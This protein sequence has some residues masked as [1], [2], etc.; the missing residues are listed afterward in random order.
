MSNGRGASGVKQLLV[1][2]VSSK[3]CGLPLEHVL[4]T[5]RPLPVERLASMPSFVC[6]LSLIRGRPT[7]VLDGRSLLGGAAEQ[8]RSARLVTLKVGER[9]LAL[10]VDAVVGIRSVSTELLEE[11]PPLLRDSQAEQVGA[12]GTLDAEL[13]LVLEHTRLLSEAHFRPLQEASA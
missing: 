8:S 10:W 3:L 4:E 7:P 1:C 13:L 6:G 5:M 9:Q 2:R 11:L 12:I